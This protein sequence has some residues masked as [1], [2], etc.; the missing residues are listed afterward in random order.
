MKIFKRYSNLKKYY[1]TSDGTA[2][3]KRHHA[4]LHAKNLD[5][6]K[7]TEVEKVIEEAEAKQAEAK[8]K[9]EEEVKVR[10]KKL[11]NLT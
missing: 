6:K 3:F 10:A 7:V 4:E 2:F 5:N 9:Q 1:K 8:A 11:E